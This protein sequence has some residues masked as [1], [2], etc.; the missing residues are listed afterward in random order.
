MDSKAQQIADAT[1]SI[2][3]D[4]ID[5]RSVIREL[6]Q[7][8]YSA[9]HKSDLANKYLPLAYQLIELS[10]SYQDIQNLLDL[11]KK[12]DIQESIN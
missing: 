12:Q 8:F 6:D 4:L 10:K 2:E 7:F 5:A 3:Q 1:G 11:N 9:T